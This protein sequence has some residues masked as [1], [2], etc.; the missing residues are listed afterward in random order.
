MEGDEESSPGSDL[1]TAERKADKNS[2]HTYLNI[3]CLI[4]KQQKHFVEGAAEEV[5]N[6]YRRQEHYTSLT[7]LVSG[8]Y[9][10]SSGTCRPSFFKNTQTNNV[11]SVKEKCLRQYYAHLLTLSLFMH[12][13]DSR[14]TPRRPFGTTA[15]SFSSCGISVIF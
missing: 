3:I 14:L 1:I 2:G 10:L 4:M 15:I 7:C 12:I 11:T 5:E 8:V 9:Y 13:P 6:Q